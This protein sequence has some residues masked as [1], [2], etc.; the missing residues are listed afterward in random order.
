MLTIFFHVNLEAFSEAAGL[1]LVSSGDVDDA[2]SVFLADVLQ[3]S[4]I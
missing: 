2:S 1:T 3:V 4:K